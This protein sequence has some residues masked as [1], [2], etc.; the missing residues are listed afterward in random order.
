M[1][2]MSLKDPQETQ[3]K[4]KVLHLRKQILLM[5]SNHQE[6]QKQLAHQQQ[7]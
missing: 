6:M 5:M 3:D 4:S 7:E 1:L 2:Q